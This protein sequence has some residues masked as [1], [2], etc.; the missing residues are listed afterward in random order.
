MTIDPRRMLILANR[1]CNTGT[2]RSCHEQGAAIVP[3]VK[4]PPPYFQPVL[5]KAPDSF[6]AIKRLWRNVIGFTHARAVTF[7]KVV[8]PW[9]PFRRPA[10]TVA[11]LPDRDHPAAD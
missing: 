2:F 10:S 8:T 6:T 11:S 9:L 1:G 3:D 4:V 5:G 7:R